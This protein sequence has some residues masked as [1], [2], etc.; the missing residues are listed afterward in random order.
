LVIIII[1]MIIVI[2]IFVFFA[3]VIFVLAFTFG[4]NIGSG[5]LGGDGKAR[6]GSSTE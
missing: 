4:G 2:N 6:L 5:L 1:I 3:S